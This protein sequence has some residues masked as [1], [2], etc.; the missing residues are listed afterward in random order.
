MVAFRIVGYF[1]CGG[2]GNDIHALGWGA[3]EVDVSFSDR[4]GLHFGCFSDREGLH[5]GCF[6]DRGVLLLCALPRPRL[7]KLWDLTRQ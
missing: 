1:E 7:V 3:G 6:S 5:S 2:S 4:G